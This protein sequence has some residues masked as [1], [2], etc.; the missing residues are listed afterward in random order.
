MQSRLRPLL[1]TL[2]CLL[3]STWTLSAAARPNILWI[4]SEDN[5]PH[6]GC[7][8]DSYADTPNI[9]ALAARGT[10]YL[11]AWSSAP[12]CAPAR[13]A[14]ISGV[15]PPSTGAEHMR[16]M[17]PMPEFMA[18]FPQLLRRAGYYCSNN[19]KE[20]YN[21]EKPDRVWDDSSNKAH[22]KNRKEDQPFFAVF[23]F[24]VS[25]E[26][27]IRKRPH[28]AIHD[29]A[30]VRV[31]AYHPNTRDVRRDWAQYYD[32]VTEMDAQV[33]AV[34]RELDEAG[35]AED[36]IVFYYGDHGSG[37][38][39]NKRWPY[40]SGLQ[41]PLIVHIPKQFSFMASKDYG[42]G[43]STD[44][45]VDFTDLAPTALSIA[46]IKP[47]KWMQGRAFLGLH[48][49]SP[50]NF[51]YGFRGRMDERYDLVRSVRD[52]RYVYIRHY[53][54]HKIYGQHIDY[55]FQTPTTRVWKELH[56][57]GKL[58]PEQDRFWLTK[59]VE[60]LFDLQ[61]DPDEVRNLAESPDHRRILRR[62]RNAQE[63]WIRD[64]HDVGF[65]PEDEIH[66]RSAESTPYEMGHDSLEY[67]MR[68]VQDMASLAAGFDMDD[69]P[70]LKQA[71]QRDDYSAVRYWAALGL[72]IRG[73]D[74][75]QSSRGLLLEA[76]NDSSPSV[77]IV[78]CEALAKYGQ[79]TDLDAAMPRLLEWAH[80]DRHSL[81][82]SML[83]LNV[84]D[85]LGQRALPWKEKIA[86]LPA[87][88]EDLDARL[89]GYVPRLLEHI[90]A[91][92]ESD[93]AK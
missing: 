93:P 26:S 76:M 18:M 31:P 70:R 22:W 7:Y 8:G 23:N 44:R 61:E 36:T 88:Q 87:K 43:G 54:P 78:A 81:S 24:T 51:I 63:D 91:N 16:S 27:Q 49:D 47:P 9:D 72:L 92:L 66:A 74:A 14:I 25:H 11:H 55:M 84:I 85:D 82:L 53:M 75:V 57:Q 71:L 89:Q 3:L 79:A 48:Q 52:E 33:G 68:R 86:S 59:P 64:I 12:V 90:M 34:L 80:L 29:P 28:Q 2:G 50:R 62:L 5:G 4:T 46:G 35:L 83:A 58:T 60:E 6:L 40:N 15:Y 45:L 42:A 39:R 19:S 67:P 17:V 38:P 20:D 65:L 56:D 77:A 69:V 41:V 37:M 13:T 30:K 73:K 1:T 10:R 32:K 21:L